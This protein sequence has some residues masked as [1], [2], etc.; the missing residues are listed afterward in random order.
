MFT[1][2][3][4]TRPQV[5]KFYDLGQAWVKRSFD[6]QLRSLNV[7]VDHAQ[8]CRLA[9]FPIISPSPPIISFHIYLLAV[10]PLLVE[11]TELEHPR[12]AHSGSF[13]EPW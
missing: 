13:L 9:L 4:R 12:R 11:L 5:L 1:Y 8:E 7:N 2:L 6:C 10:N 3:A